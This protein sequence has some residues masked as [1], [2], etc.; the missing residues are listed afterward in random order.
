MKFADVRRIAFPTWVAVPLRVSPAVLE[1]SLYDNESALALSVL[2][3]PMKANTVT[4]TILVILFDVIVDV[5]VLASEI[6][7]SRFGLVFR[8][9]AQRLELMGVSMD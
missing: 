8:Q 4:G 7:K 6:S 3:T 5:I 1:K 9:R 2:R